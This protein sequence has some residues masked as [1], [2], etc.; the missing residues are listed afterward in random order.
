VLWFNPR[1][2]DELKHLKMRI[3]YR[4]HFLEI[5]LTHARLKVT[6]LRTTKMPI[7]IG[8]MENVYE[9]SAES[10]RVF[11]FDSKDSFRR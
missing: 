7:R 2:P 9:L 5:D 4:Y 1:L 11:K 10:T 6:S 8:F 3:R